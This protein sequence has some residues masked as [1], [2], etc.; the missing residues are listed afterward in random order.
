MFMWIFLFS[1]ALLW[2]LFATIQDVRTREVANWITFSLLSI[3]FVSRILFSISNGL[4]MVYFGLMSTLILFSFS[5]IFY[6]GRVFAGGDAKLLIGLGMF[7]PGDTYSSVFYNSLIFTLSLLLIGA[8]YSVFWSFYVAI[9]RK[10]TFVREFRRYG[11]YYLVSTLFVILTF[12]FSYLLKVNLGIYLIFSIGSFYVLT[13]P[14]L[15]SIDKSMIVLYDPRKLTPGD[16]IVEDVKVGNRIIRRSVDGLS[17]KDISFL[18]RSNKKVLVK[19]G[20]PFVPAF[21]ITF[22]LMVFFFVLRGQNFL[23]QLISFLS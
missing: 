21:L 7:I 10:K 9:S 5:M 20:A 16:W 3:G 19:E 4:E 17:E 6:Y 1:I 11:E 22:V 2:I 14:Y 12:L 13:Y 15:R 8:I 18:I 23:Y